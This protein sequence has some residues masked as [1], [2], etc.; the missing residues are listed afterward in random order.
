MTCG[1]NVTFETYSTKAHN[2]RVHFHALR[3]SVPPRYIRIH[4]LFSRHY[5]FARQKA[6][7]ARF[8]RSP[9]TVRT[10]LKTPRVYSENYLKNWWNWL[11]AFCNIRMDNLVETSCITLTEI[12]PFL[13]KAS[14]SPKKISKHSKYFETLGLHPFIS[15]KYMTTRLSFPMF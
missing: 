15:L 5:L 6:I 3:R 1:Q 11:F 13:S 8:L 10:A 12:P 4:F 14:F 7:W 2:A 9:F